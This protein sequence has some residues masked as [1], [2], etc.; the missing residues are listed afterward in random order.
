MKKMKSVLSI[1]LVVTMML[2]LGAVNFSFAA[3]EVEYCAREGCY[4]VCEWRPESSTGC[5]ETRGLYCRICNTRK[6]GE[7][8]YNHQYEE[9][10]RVDATC[11]KT[12]LVYYACTKPDCYATKKEVLPIV[13][14]AHAYG[15]YIVTKEPACDTTGSKYALC[16]NTYTDEDGNTIT[17]GYKNVVTIPVDD[18]A[19]VFVG[20]WI[21]RVDPTCEADGEAYR[22]CTVCGDDEEIK[23]IPAHSATWHEYDRDEPTCLREGTRYVVCTKCNTNGTEVIPVSEEHSWLEKTEEYVAPTCTEEGQR[24]FVCRWHTDTEKTDI[25]PTTKHTF[26]N[27]V[28]N[29]DAKCGVDGTKTAKCENCDAEDTVADIGSALKHT[30]SKWII[31]SGDCGEENS[32]VTAYKN[33]VY[34]KEVMIPETTFSAGTHPNRLVVTVEP[35]C[36]KNGYV[37]DMCTDCGYT[38]AKATLEAGHVLPDEWT[39][40][41]APTCSEEGVEIKQCANCDY[42]ETQSIAKR[43]HV[44]LTFEPAVEATC[45]KAGHT[46]SKY[47]VNCSFTVFAEPVEAFGHN[48]A[49]N[50]GCC[51]RCYVYFIDTD[52]GIVDCDC[53][54]HNPDG[55]AKFIF[56]LLNFIYQVLGINQTCDC[57]KVHYEGAG[58]F[59]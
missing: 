50:D 36:I 44:Y 5:E 21:T 45:L 10:T 38:W 55:L 30:E 46:E 15:E 9:Y 51:D 59:G 54:C 42:F 56:K 16:T 32:V 20:D 3:D 26:E 48:D 33:C 58:L 14:N 37:A 27:Y 4:G 41:K 43:E 39:V 31:T 25:L 12:G 23:V 8:I 57:G 28:S 40:T 13:A 24:V 53:I 52:A 17:C 2:S 11:V 35:T 19:H 29:N 34:C 22:I 6:I 7:T 49:N 47:C 1:L 18:T